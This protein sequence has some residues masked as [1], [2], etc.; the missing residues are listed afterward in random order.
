MN[1]YQ[2]GKASFKKRE[3]LAAMSVF[4]TVNN[5]GLSMQCYMEQLAVLCEPVRRIWSKFSM[6][7][8]PTTTPSTALSPCSSFMPAFHIG[9]SL[10]IPVVAANSEETLRL[11]LL[12]GR[13]HT[14][15]LNYLS[16]FTPFNLHSEIRNS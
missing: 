13:I 2:R 10:K 16:H 9:G 12:T 1:L 11:L 6:L 4:W 14:K 3:T 5:N 8:R 15:S 7:H